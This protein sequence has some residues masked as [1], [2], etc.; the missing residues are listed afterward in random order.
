MS[1]HQYSPDTSEGARKRIRIFSVLV[2]IGFL[3]LWMRVWYLQVIKG[4][5][6]KELS[7]NN[8]IRTVSL[9]GFR[10]T[11][12]DRNGKI[13]VS[14]RPAFNLYIIP[15]DAK[16]LTATLEL[17]QERIDFDTEKVRQH[18]GRVPSFQSV[19]IQGDID[20]D[21]AAFVEENK[22]YLPGVSLKVEPLR[23]YVYSEFASHALGYL[24]EISKGKL[25]DL[26][27]PEYRQGDMIGKDGLENIYEFFLRGKKGYKD[28]EVDVSGRELKILRQVPPK[29]GNHI[30]LTVDVRI[31]EAVEKLMAGTPDK[32]VAG[33][34]VAMNPKTGDILA[35]ASK[36]SFDPN[37]F[38]AGITREDWRSL[39]LDETHPLQNRVIDGQYP[40]GS[41]YKIVTAY[42]GL[43]ERVISPETIIN[44]PG[45]FTLGRKTYR[46]WKKG[47]HGNMN[48]YTAIV[49]SCDVFFYTVGTRLGIDRLAGYAKKF[50]LGA[51][52]GIN[53][54]GE[55]PGLIPTSEWKQAAKNEPWMGGETVSAS[56]G[57]GYDLVTP[58]QQA[59][60]LSAV[61]N[62][63]SLF[64]PSLVKRVEDADG[65][66]VQEFLPQLLRKE[67]LQH[68][69]LS[70]IRKALL[71]VVNEPGGTGGRSR[72]KSILVSGKTGT[73][74]VVG[75]KKDDEHLKDDEIPY[76]MRDH[77]WFI[78]FAPFDDPEIVVS[79]IVEHGGHGGSTAAPI[80]KEIFQTYFT[81]YPPS[82]K[83][84]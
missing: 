20:R 11:I 4:P 73:S 23:S 30:V 16:D 22:L 7:E 62:G 38:A 82:D 53:L 80:A 54:T 56:I 17:L 75:M 28:V 13:M 79:I 18:I 50:G 2:I 42:A 3:C 78:A 15:E 19:L 81:Y 47:G 83:N 34:V 5:Y 14:V 29:S 52:T 25:E 10:G 27:D 63:G 39:A 6:L 1:L 51:N 72:L 35:I 12:K 46:C 68:D 36:P 60:M 58:L 32:P 57:Q 48:V 74:Q 71:G 41:T 66:V 31:Q 69:T 40:P 45:H 26:D 37:L 24:G 84:A 33:S 65:T 9:P 67:N 44:C 43:E 61:A 49:Q 21:D 8:R 64:R 59:V 77:A 70:L 55:K 76:L